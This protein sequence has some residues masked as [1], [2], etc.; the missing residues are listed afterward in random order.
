MMA[1]GAALDRDDR[2]AALALVEEL[3]AVLLVLT[4]DDDEQPTLWQLISLQRAAGLSG[5][6][7]RGRSALLLQ[8]VTKVRDLG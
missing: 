6:A 7:W 3:R 1:I 2:R 5:C 4:P 8:R